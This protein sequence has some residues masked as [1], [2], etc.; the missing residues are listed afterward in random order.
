[1]LIHEHR[2]AEGELLD[3][4]VLAARTA[5]PERTIRALP[6]GRRTGGAVLTARADEALDQTLLPVV[7]RPENPGSDPVRAPM[8]RYGVRATGPGVHASLTREQLERLIEG[9][10]RSVV[11]AEGSTRR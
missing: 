8:D 3:P 11:P 9:V 6:A 7:R 2:L 5:L 10:V 4:R 1:M